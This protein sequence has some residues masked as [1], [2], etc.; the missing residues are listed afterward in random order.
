MPTVTV[1]MAWF[2]LALMLGGAGGLFNAV[3]S[4]DLKPL[5]ALVKSCRGRKWVVR[6]GL[7]GNIGLAALASTT[8]AW[9]VTQP[10]GFDRPPDGGQLLWLLVTSITIGFV[11]ARL[12]TN[13]ADKRLLREAVCKASAAPAAPPETIRAMETAPPWDVYTTTD[14]LMP[15][16]LSSWRMGL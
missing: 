16:P 12:A 9:A 7:V 13:E 5:P 15:P 1:D 6:I 4:H 10:G 11:A 2:S 3:L 14:A 8:C